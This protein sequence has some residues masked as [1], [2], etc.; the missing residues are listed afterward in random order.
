V[1]PENGVPSG[2]VNPARIFPA[3]PAQLYNLNDR[4]ELKSGMRADLILFTLEDFTMDVKK[5]IVA[6]EIVFESSN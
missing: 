1:S 4:G 2:K 3:Y 5:T 6:G